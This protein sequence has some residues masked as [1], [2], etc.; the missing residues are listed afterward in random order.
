MT[1]VG[2]GTYLLDCKQ[3]DGCVCTGFLKEPGTGCGVGVVGKGHPSKFITTRGHQ[4]AP[5]EREGL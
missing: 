3:P 2:T 4:L 1:L 5:F